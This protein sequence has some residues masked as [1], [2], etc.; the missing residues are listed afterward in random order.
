M[1][2]KYSN[3][4]STPYHDGTSPP[5]TL[6][7][8]PSRSVG[9]LLVLNSTAGRGVVASIFCAWFSS[10]CQCPQIVVLVQIVLLAT[11]FQFICMNQFAP[12]TPVD[13]VPNLYFITSRANRSCT[14]FSTPCCLFQQAQSFS[15]YIQWSSVSWP[16][17]CNTLFGAVAE[18][19]VAI[20]LNLLEN[21]V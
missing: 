8:V 7:F 18:F 14:H 4:H 6:G 11:S 1:H 17:D 5:S 12:I 3:I 21:E 20:H 15:W 19:G 2:V 10:G 16:D 13:I 9:L